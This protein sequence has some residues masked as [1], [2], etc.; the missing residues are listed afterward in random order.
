MSAPSS[1]INRIP[2]GLLGLTGLKS[3]G[4]NPDEL[5]G[6]VQP[7][8]DMMAFWLGSL[9]QRIFGQNAAPAVG[10][11]D[12]TTGDSFTVP[13]GKAWFIAAFTVRGVVTDAGDVLKFVPVVRGPPTTG[14]FYTGVN[15][16]FGATAALTVGA[17]STN[18][19]EGVLPLLPAGQWCIAGPGW[20][21]GA[22]VP[23]VNIIAAGVSLVYQALI[24]EVDI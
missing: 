21:L 15:Q 12:P 6:F 10:F 2:A 8:V 23:V 1:P 24:V 5:A 19:N 11:N 16:N 18:A 20:R 3:L 22:H 7:T 4:Q 14:A 13:L 17:T 9:T